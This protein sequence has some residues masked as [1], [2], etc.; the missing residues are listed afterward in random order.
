MHTVRKRTLV[1]GEE[2]LLRNSRSYTASQS[3]TGQCQ[4]GKSIKPY[5]SIWRAPCH[6]VRILENKIT[7][8]DFQRHRCQAQKLVLN[9]TRRSHRSAASHH[10]RTAGI[11]TVSVRNLCGVT[12]DHAYILNRNLQFIR[13]DLAQ[14]CRDSLTK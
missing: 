14:G 6:N 13:D 3:W 2:I 4:S 11:T 7:D 9:L 5:R 8:V 10:G 1:S 12:V